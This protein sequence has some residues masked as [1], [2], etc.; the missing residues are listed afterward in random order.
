MYHG[1]NIKRKALFCILGIIVLIIIASTCCVRHAIQKGE[2]YIPVQEVKNELE[3]LSEIENKDTYEN[4]QKYE[5]FLKEEYLTYRDVKKILEVYPITVEDEKIPHQKFGSFVKKAEWENCLEKIIAEYGKNQIALQELVLIANADCVFTEDGN[6]FTKEQILAY[7][8]N[9]NETAVFLSKVPFS[10]EYLG[11]SIK[12][13]IY[14]ESILAIKQQEENATELKN[15]FVMKETEKTV[16]FFWKHYEITMPKS[17]QLT[18]IEEQKVADLTIKEGI[19]QRIREKENRISGKVLKITENEIEM[20]GYGNVKI[21]PDIAVY[22]LYGSMRSKEKEDIRIG[23]TFTDF[24]VQDNEIQAA[25]MIKEENMDFIRVLIKNSDYEGKYHKT[26]EVSCDCSYQMIFYEDGLETERKN[27]ECKD[28]I[29]ISEK[30]IPEKN[31]RI[32]II[33]DVLSGKMTLCN[34]TRNQGNP[35]YTGTLEIEKDREGILIINEVLLEEY[36]YRVVPSEM[37]ASYPLEALKA[38]AVCART[39]AYGKMMHAGLMQYGAHVD[40]SAGF[41]VYNNINEQFETTKA[42]KDTFGEILTYDDEPIG[43]YYYSTSCGMGSDTS[44]WNNGEENPAYIEAQSITHE[45]EETESTDT[46]KKLSEE[47]AFAEYIKNGNCDDYEYEE[48]W[49]RWSYTVENPD[50][51]K[52]EI[53]LRERYESNHNRILTYQDGEFVSKPIKSLG[54]IEEICIEKRNAGGVADELIIYGTKAVVKV[55]SE[56]NIR[57][58]LNDGVTKVIRKTGDYVNSPKILPSAFFII[59]TFKEDGYVVGYKLSGGGYGHGVGMS[60]NGAKAMAADGKS[61]EEILTFFYKNCRIKSI[62]PKGESESR[63]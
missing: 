4:L 7:D 58:V 62:C 45:K 42:V 18:S 29:E 44:I 33:P 27:G 19:I 8:E 53:I 43:A 13:Y 39:Y 38:Q 40:D 3:A 26:I 5:D 37:P 31:G 36:L 24:V 1:K 47:A 28:I 23:Y 48:G 54:N 21:S 51:E 22:Q 34:V 49:Y 2:T 52:L 32:K 41:Q 10:D 56:L 16:T 20:E 11:S 46:A 30:D 17:E 50:V 63:V 61:H 14:K 59:D 55:I 12:G 9:K 57:Y 60:Q 15:T 35:A 25:L 6:S